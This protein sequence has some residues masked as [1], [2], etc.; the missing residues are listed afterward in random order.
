MDS[1][2]RDAEKD[3]HKYGLALKKVQGA[4]AD[5]ALK[6]KNDE[7]AMVETIKKW[8]PQHSRSIYYAHKS[9]QRL[10]GQK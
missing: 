9:I 3:L 7:Y 1:I 5:I 6:L 10:T 4:E 2:K 8:R